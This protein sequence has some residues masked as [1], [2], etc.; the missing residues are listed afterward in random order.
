M[1]QENNQE[2][3]IIKELFKI[4]AEKADEVSRESGQDKALQENVL[5]WVKLLQKI[6]PYKTPFCLDRDQAQDYLAGKPAVLK[7]YG[8]H[9]DKCADYCQKLV[10]FYKK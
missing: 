8:E 6:T 7:Q 5:A 1:N 4:W 10:E 9:V 2:D 3:K